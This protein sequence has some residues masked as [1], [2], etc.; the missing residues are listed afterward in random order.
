MVIHQARTGRLFH[1]NRTAAQVW[2]ALRAGGSEEPAAQDLARA[3][4]VD[5]AAVRRD[6]EAFVGTLREAELLDQ[7][8][9][10]AGPDAAPPRPPQ[11]APA[12]GAPA[13]D[14]AYRVGD[15]TVRVSCYSPEVAAAFAPLAAP[16][17]VA[18]GVTGGP[19]AEVRLTLHRGREGFVLARD[20]RPIDLLP[21]AAGA[22]WA[23]V[24]QLVTASRPRP[25]LALL[26]GGA[27]ATP[28]G[29]LLLCGDSG[30]GKS[31]FLAGLL[32]AGLPF[33]AD[34][35]LPLEAGTGL[36]WPVP[37]AI[38]IKEG[39]WPVVDPMF[40]E[41]ADLP[42]VR[43]G[44]RTM[45]YLWPDRAVA[46]APSSGRPAAALLFPRYTKD[47]S[48]ALRPLDAARALVLLGEG[49]SAL[50]STD[51]GLAEFLAWLGNVPAYELTYGRLDEAVGLTRRHLTADPR[52]GA[53]VAAARMPGEAGPERRPA[54]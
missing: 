3:H 35:I 16:A 36:V 34:D 33:V 8:A 12:Q 18:E 43:L 32:H 21:T 6:L 42:V 51:A 27:V 29:C 23:M 53:D 1:L 5:P 54:A 31:T 15:V 52:A 11:G 20:G 4:G 30:A 19:A 2:Y 9:P 17:R 14:A 44:R 25:W 13:L 24:R 39:S 46:S 41:L 26:H 28:A 49:G 22:R 45:R 47:A 10:V 40:P 7:D 37:L 38:S 50:P 48:A